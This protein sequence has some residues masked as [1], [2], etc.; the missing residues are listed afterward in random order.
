MQHV[1]LDGRRRRLLVTVRT[2][3]RAEKELGRGGEKFPDLSARLRRERVTHDSLARLLWICLIRDDPG[4]TVF[5]VRELI[6]H[7]APG[8]IWLYVTWAKADY[9]I[10]LAIQG[11]ERLL[12]LLDGDDNV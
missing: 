7:R 10:R 5:Q 8:P 4:L 9:A 1:K 3:E 11:V 6:R 2:M 12:W